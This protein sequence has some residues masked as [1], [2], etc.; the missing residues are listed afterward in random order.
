MPALTCACWKYTYMY[1][2]KTSAYVLCPALSPSFSSQTGSLN[3]TVLLS[4]LPPHPH[5]STEATG[6]CTHS[7]SRIGT[8]FPLSAFTQPQILL[9]HF[10]RLKMQLLPLLSLLSPIDT[11]VHIF[12]YS[13]GGLNCVQYWVG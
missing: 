11:C 4:V 7:H 8:L 9:S 5:P 10:P 1:I 3:L 13:C 6:A 12:L 2:W